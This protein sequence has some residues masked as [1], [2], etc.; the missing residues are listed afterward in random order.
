[1]AALAALSPGDPGI[2]AAS[3]SEPAL[4]MWGIERFARCC[5]RRLAV[6]APRFVVFA[7]FGSGH[8]GRQLCGH[9]LDGSR[10]PCRKWS[11]KTEF[12]SAGKPS[13]R[14]RCCW[15]ASEDGVENAH[16]LE[17]HFFSNPDANLRYA[18]LADY[19][20]APIA[21]TT[22]DDAERLESRTRAAIA[23]LNARYGEQFLFLHP[24][25]PLERHRRTLDGLG[26]QARKI[27]RIQPLFAGRAQSIARTNAHQRRARRANWTKSNSSSRSTPTRNCPTAP[28]AA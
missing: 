22:A 18:L 26:A 28:R 27:G 25:A 19:T 24:R 4:A 15:A 16:Q 5:W 3:R 8:A 20:D 12:P 1:M 9:A 10:A 21:R 6:A 13:S 11:S 23:D 7:L 14:F 2:L 17:I